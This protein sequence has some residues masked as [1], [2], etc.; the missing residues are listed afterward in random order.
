MMRWSI[1]LAVVLGIAA[2]SLSGIVWLSQV[3]A[4]R[5]ERVREA[6]AEHQLLQQ[7]L[8]LLQ[9]EDTAAIASSLNEDMESLQIR[10]VELLTRQRPPAGVLTVAYE[11]AVLQRLLATD[12]D[13]PVSV[14]RLD[15]KL[16]LQHSLGL[17]DMLER[18]DDS[19]STWPHEIRACELVRLPQQQLNA[20]CVVDFYH[21][22][23]KPRQHTSHSSL[24]AGTK[25]M[26][27]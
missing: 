8:H 7:Q 10:L 15:L 19:I 25:V 27:G 4:L 12:E 26:R 17:V 14:L 3:S 9:Q 11:Q 20:R 21:W 23:H 16:T 18:I 6:R 1:A 22:N 13:E 5:L 2:V 24:V